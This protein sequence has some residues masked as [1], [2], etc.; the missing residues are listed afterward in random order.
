MFNWIKNKVKKALD[1]VVEFVSGLNR[2]QVVTIVG[3]TVAVAWGVGSL[4]CPPLAL[5]L[6]M[7]EFAFMVFVALVW[8]ALI[9]ALVVNMGWALTVKAHQ[10]LS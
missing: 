6:L 4:F 8:V 9:V 2:D 7:V 5:A 1:T 3:S 10:I